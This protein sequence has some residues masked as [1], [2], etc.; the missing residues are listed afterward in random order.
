MIAL[1]SIRSTLQDAIEADATLGSYEVL[2]DD[3]YQHDEIEAAL[4][5]DGVVIIITP[6]IT[7]APKQQ[8]AGAMLVEASFA[9]CISL[10]P[11]VNADLTTPLVMDDLLSALMKVIIGIAPE[12]DNDRY[13]IDNEGARLVNTDD[14]GPHKYIVA[15]TKGALL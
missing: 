7:V 2:L 8:E 10:N 12:T 13:R 1:T 14:R 15:V 9:A 6:F 3:G 5:D 11:S 4:R